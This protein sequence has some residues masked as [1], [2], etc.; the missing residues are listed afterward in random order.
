MITFLIIDA[1]LFVPQ[2]ESENNVQNEDKN[3]TLSMDDI[4]TTNALSLYSQIKYYLNKL[5]I[6]NKLI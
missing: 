4:R 5:F 1:N 3:L 2:D 6:L